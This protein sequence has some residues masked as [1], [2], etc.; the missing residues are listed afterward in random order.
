VAEDKSHFACDDLGLQ[1]I[2]QYK[3]V[4]VEKGRKGLIGNKYGGKDFWDD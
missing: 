1:L 4:E 2:Q 3:N